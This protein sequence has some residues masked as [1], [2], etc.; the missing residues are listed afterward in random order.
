MSFFTNKDRWKNKSM[1][2]S[3]LAAVP[4]LLSLFHIQVLPDEWQAIEYV[5]K[6]VLDALVV[7]GILMDPTSEGYADN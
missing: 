3:L 1:Y 5:V 6:G 2:V 4:A 7:L